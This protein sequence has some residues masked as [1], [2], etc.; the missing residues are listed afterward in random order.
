[1]EISVKE[2]K[3]VIINTHIA[4]QATA[5]IGNRKLAENYY[6]TMFLTMMGILNT[7]KCNCTSDGQPSSTIGCPVHGVCYR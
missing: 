4:G 1:M 3:E 6:K 2:F 7:P 5:R